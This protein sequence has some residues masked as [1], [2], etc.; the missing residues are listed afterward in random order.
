MLLKAL[1]HGEAWGW[2]VRLKGI[3]M[4]GSFRLAYPYHPSPQELWREEYDLGRIHQAMVCNGSFKNEIR[5]YCYSG[6]SNYYRLTATE[7][8]V[9]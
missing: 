7:Q 9:I 1:E 3:G 6:N 5:G 4:S 2:I 8:V